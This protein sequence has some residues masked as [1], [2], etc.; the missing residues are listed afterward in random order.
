[1]G[2]ERSLNE[3]EE[4]KLEDSMAQ[5]RYARVFL[6]YLDS[7]E[8]LLDLENS[9][10]AV[11]PARDLVDNGRDMYR[12][13]DE[14]SIAMERVLS[15]RRPFGGSLE[16]LEFAVGRFDVDLDIARANESRNW[17]ALVKAVNFVSH[18]ESWTANPWY[19][20]SMSEQHDLLVSDVRSADRIRY[21]RRDL[22]EMLFGKIPSP[23]ALEVCFRLS[24]GKLV[25]TVPFTI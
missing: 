7:A 8:E 5:Y 1:M 20:G 16:E 4:L 10:S 2:E 13:Y 9:L 14:A 22:C 17:Q 21:Y 23:D 24:F 6:Q 19:N 11:E 12:N 3:N 15:P 25:D 18:D